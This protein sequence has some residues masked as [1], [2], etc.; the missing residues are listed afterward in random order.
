[1]STGLAVFFGL[2]VLYGA[3]SVWLGRFSVT[4]PIVF[5]IVGALL[6]SKGLVTAQSAELL[7]EMT[8]A[9]LL[10]ADASTLAFRQV[11]DDAGPPARLLLIALPLVVVLGGLI[12]YALFPK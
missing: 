5:V 8:L 4:M 6:G 9:L 10:F 12:A 3:V 2:V 1:M 11:R 7:I